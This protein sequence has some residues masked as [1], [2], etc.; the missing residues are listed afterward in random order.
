MSEK[1]KQRFLASGQLISVAEAAEQT[2]YSPE[3]LSLLARKGRIQAVKIARD[4]LTT[5]A[6]VFNYLKQQETKH[7]KSLD[8]LVVAGRSHYV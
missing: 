2:P 7:R 3:Y 4:W 8:A 6:A 1:E 5:R